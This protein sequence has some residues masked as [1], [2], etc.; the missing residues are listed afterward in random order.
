M[1]QTL[2][3]WGLNREIFM[4]GLARAA[5][6]LGASMLIV[7]IPLFVKDFGVGF[8]GYPTTLVIGILLSIYGFTNSL[9][10]PAVGVWVDRLGVNKPFLMVGLLVYSVA[11]LMF[12]WVRTFSGMAILWVLQ[13]VGVALTLPPSLTLMTEYTRRKTRGTAMAFYNVMRLLGFSVGPLMA[14]F[15]VMYWGFAE[16]LALGA[17]AGLVGFFLVLFLVREV[18]TGP[19]PSSRVE[20]GLVESVRGFFDRDMVDFYKLAFANLTMAMSVSLV[21]ALENQFNERLNQ[22]TGAYGV[23]FSALVVTLMIFQIPIGRL[24]DKMG[25][26]ILIVIGLYGLIPSTLWMGYV[27]STEQF[28]VA[29]ML[30]GIAVGAIAAPSFALGGDKSRRGKQGREFSLITMAFGLGI[31]L[32][33]VTAGLLNGAFFF[34]APFLVGAVLILLSALLVQFTVP[35]GKLQ[36]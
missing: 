31:G 13:G 36:Q 32:G 3:N 21:A 25:R 11:T 18:K 6:S 7:L 28:V 10:Q 2:K 1:I 34:Q 9:A 27:T 17:A 33:P 5:D 12:V 4:L 26:K 30:Q 19:D 8:L 16:V 23:A 24:A 14:G 20:V 35:E 22:S 29:R 15:M